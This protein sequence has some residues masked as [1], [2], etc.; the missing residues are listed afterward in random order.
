MDVHY[1]DGTMRCKHC[2]KTK[3]GTWPI[4]LQDVLNGVVQRELEEFKLAHTN[5][6]LQ[7]YGLTTN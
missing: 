7:A 3:R 1:K 6:A 2:G 5:C 4:T